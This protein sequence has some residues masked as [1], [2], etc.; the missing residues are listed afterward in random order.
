MQWIGTFKNPLACCRPCE[1]R[2]A[3]P[4]KALPSAHFYGRILPTFLTFNSL[5]YPIFSGL[6]RSGNCPPGVHFRQESSRNRTA[7]CGSIPN[8]RGHLSLAVKSRLTL[9]YVELGERAGASVV[10]EWSRIRIVAGLFPNDD[11]WLRFIGLS[12]GEV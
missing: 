4:A 12:N 6:P 7:I 2:T 10:V 9:P 5:C 11:H 1:S 3:K 8:C